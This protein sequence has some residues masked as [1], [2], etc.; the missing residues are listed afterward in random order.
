M[1]VVVFLHLYTSGKAVIV[2]KF[3]IQCHLSSG[4]AY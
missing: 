3:P 2:N 4:E 1:I